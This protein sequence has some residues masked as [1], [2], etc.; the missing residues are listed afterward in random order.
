MRSLSTILAPVIGFTLICCPV[1]SQA[2]EFNY[3]FKQ[4]LEDG[5]KRIVKIRSNVGRDLLIF[6]TTASAWLAWWWNAKLKSPDNHPSDSQTE[7]L[8]AAG[9]VP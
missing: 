3:K 2:L 8:P 9:A 7:P 4:T 6:G 1:P 5:S